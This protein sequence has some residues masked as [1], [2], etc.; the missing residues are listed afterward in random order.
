MAPENSPEPAGG[1]LQEEY[2][3]LKTVLNSVDVLVYVSDLDSHEVL[4][5][6]DYGRKLCGDVGNKK[7]YEYLQAGQTEPCAF[8][9]NSQL[10]DA[11]GRPTPVL[12]WEFQNT[13][14]QQWFQCRDQVIPWTDGRLVRLEIATDI[15]ERKRTEEELVRARQKADELARRDALTGIYNRRALL[16][17]AGFMANYLRRYPRPVSLV[18]VDVDHFKA[19]NDHHGHAAGD[20]VL[21]QLAHAM[22]ASLREV[23]QLY[24]TGGEEFVLLLYDCDE[25]HAFEL[26][27]RLRHAIAATDLAIQGQP[28]QLT[29]S[30]GVTR[31]RSDQDIDQLLAE[32]DQAMYAAKQLGRNQTIRFSEL[33]AG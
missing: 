19:V 16:E 31:Y 1:S 33:T 29:C 5:V 17:H 14:T 21:V 3:A 32:A 4:F 26:V 15:T 24:R 9:T 23:D 8:C 27:E 7:C 25:E 22:R 18:M 28:L 12:V 20:Q 11:D 6:N 10:I 2:Q 13:R 30:F